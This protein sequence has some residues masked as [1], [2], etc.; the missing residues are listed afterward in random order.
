M[1]PCD[2]PLTFWPVEIYGTFI[3]ELLNN[4]LLLYMF[5]EKLSTQD[6]CSRHLTRPP[7]DYKQPRNGAQQPSLYAGEECIFSVLLYGNV[8]SS[9]VMKL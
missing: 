8:I 4:V 1:H 7:P 9:S 5:Q 3:P 6:Q 2:L